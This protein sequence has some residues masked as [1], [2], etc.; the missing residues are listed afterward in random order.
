MTNKIRNLILRRVSNGIN[1]LT[2]TAKPE[3]SAS[4]QESY[5]RNTVAEYTTKV[6]LI[7][8]HV[9]LKSTKSFLNAENMVR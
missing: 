2:N 3:L 8:F 7:R 6:H 5:I 1:S 4:V 9:G